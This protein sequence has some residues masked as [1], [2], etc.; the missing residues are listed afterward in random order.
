MTN[1]A[2]AKSPAILVVEDNADDYEAVK[3]AFRKAGLTDAPAHAVSGEAAMEYL[4]GQSRPGLILLDLNMP[5]MGG[6]R[7]LETIKRDEKL[8]QIPVVVLTT[9]DYH[10]DI[11]TCYALGA[12][13]YIQKPVDFDVLCAAIR[14]VKEYWLDTALLPPQERQ[15]PAF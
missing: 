15:S 4:A 2:A 13:T 1:E 9:S 10:D 14:H 6:R 12:N 11:E 7:A 3:R 5:G 8:Q